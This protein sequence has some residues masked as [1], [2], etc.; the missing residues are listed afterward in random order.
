MQRAPIQHCLVLLLAT[1]L[2]SHPAR[3]QAFDD[4]R[5]FELG[6][7]FAEAERHA[8][9]R[10]WT[11]KQLSPALPG[12]WVVE[13]TNLGLL[14]CNNRIA[15]IATHQEGGLDEF[16]MI[17]GELGTLQRKYGK[18]ETRIVTLMVGTTR[19]SYVEASFAA[20]SGVNIRIR[21]DNAGG[22]SKI[23]ANFILGSACPGGPAP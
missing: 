16:A 5:G 12:S 18:P 6:R 13:G 21:L 11:L 3:A 1:V 4:L 20:P 15:L 8:R 10:G 22:P 14:S 7:T 9:E 2:C 17:A 23:L 19:V